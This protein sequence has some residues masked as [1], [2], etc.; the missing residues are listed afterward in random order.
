MRTG[1][2]FQVFL[3]STPR[4]GGPDVCQIVDRPWA[5]DVTD[6]MLLENPGQ[7]RST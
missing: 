7:T 1:P 3:L 4:R 2:P 5:A 6:V